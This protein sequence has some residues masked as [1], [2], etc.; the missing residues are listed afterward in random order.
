MKLENIDFELVIE[1]LKVCKFHEI[2]AETVEDFTVQVGKTSAIDTI[3]EM[4]MVD[5]CIRASGIIEGDCIIKIL[6]DLDKDF[7][8]EFVNRAYSHVRYAFYRY[9]DK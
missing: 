1:K 7:M 3:V 6:R 9:F 4:I 5:E 2:G 8:L